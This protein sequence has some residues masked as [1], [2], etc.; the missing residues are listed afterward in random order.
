MEYRITFDENLKPRYLH[1]SF[2]AV[3]LADNFRRQFRD[4]AVNMLSSG[5]FGDWHLSM[6][7]S[8]GIIIGERNISSEFDEETSIPAMMS[9]I[10]DDCTQVQRSISTTIHEL[11]RLD[12]MMK[13]IERAKK[14]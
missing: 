11:V 10:K 13:E 4:A 12:R 6:A 8:D 1:T 9:A 5:H 14:Q 2:T 3:D 7:E